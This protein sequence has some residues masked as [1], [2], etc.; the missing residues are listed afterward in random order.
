[1]ATTDTISSLR[2]FVTSVARVEDV[3]DH[4]RRIT[5]AGGDLVSFE[6]VGPDSFVYVLL[7]PPGRSELTVDA[8]FSWEAHFQ[9]P[10]AE[11]AVGAYYT[12]RRWDPTTTEL[13]A[14]FVLHG[15][16]G[17]ASAWAG[18]AGVGDP[19]ALWGPRTCWEPPPGVTSYVLVADETGL[20][21]VAGII[22]S[23]PSGTPIRVVAEIADAASGQELPTRAGV[24]VTWLERGGAEAGT[25]TLLVDAVRALGP[26]DPATTYAYG[27]G[28]SRAM[29]AVRRHL[30]D[31]RGF[32]LPHVSMVGYWRHSS[33]KDADVE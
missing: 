29:T 7:P 17:H 18:R 22:E 21:A 15:D 23:L 11:R 28:E 27:G 1:M 14:L 5:F 16:S 30:R 19:V 2:T 6:P 9:T 25:T 26:L 31:E 3:H 4:L 33:T 10:E 24:E 12:V 20:P 8:S 32:A 13:E